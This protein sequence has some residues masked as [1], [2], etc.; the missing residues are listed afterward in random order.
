MNC[1]R[2]VGSFMIHNNTFPIAFGIFFYA[3][4]SIQATNFIEMLELFFVLNVAA[5]SVTVRVL[6]FSLLRSKSNK[7]VSGKIMRDFLGMRQTFNQASIVSNR[8]STSKYLFSP[9]IF[10]SSVTI[11]ACVCMRERCVCLSRKQ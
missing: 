4:N 3:V 2:L 1:E 11:D 8:N 5:E 9:N 10:H 7:E 6:D